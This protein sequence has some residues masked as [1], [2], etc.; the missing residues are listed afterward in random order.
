MDSKKLAQFSISLSQGEAV[1][2]PELCD[3]AV[4]TVMLINGRAKTS[5]L[6]EHLNCSTRTVSRYISNARAPKLRRSVRLLNLLGFDVI[7]RKRNG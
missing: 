2:S 3:E 4:R 5:E 6:A 1:L 7:I